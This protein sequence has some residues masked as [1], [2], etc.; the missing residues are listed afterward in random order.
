[1]SAN[2]AE[3][4][5]KF[6]ALQ[7]RLAAVLPCAMPEAAFYLWARTPID[8]A[9]FARRL[10][11]RGERDR[12]A[13]QLPRPRRARASIPGRGPRPAGAGRRAAE[14]AEAIDRIVAFARAAL[15]RARAAAAR[16]ALRPRPD[17]VLVA[18]PALSAAA[19]P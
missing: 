12:A 13:R 7:P 15:S 10:L 17:G 18:T 14:C 11:R 5:A 16:H 6:A 8:D 2:R 4:A 9:E 1:M 3:Y 19:A